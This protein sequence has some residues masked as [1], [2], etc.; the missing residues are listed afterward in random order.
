MTFLISCGEVKK[1]NKNELSSENFKESKIQK[2]LKSVDSI[3]VVIDNTMKE[4]QDSH[5]NLEK[6]LN[7]IQ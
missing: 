6:T 2:D 5:E 1:G 3:I 7:E 4:I